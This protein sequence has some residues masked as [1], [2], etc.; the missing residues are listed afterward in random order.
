MVLITRPNAIRA[1]QLGYGAVESAPSIVVPAQ[2]L[3]LW[4]FGAR[5]AVFGRPTTRI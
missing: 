1:W 5:A 4:R 2:L 3:H